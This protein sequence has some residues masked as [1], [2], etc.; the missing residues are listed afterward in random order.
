MPVR[1]I[2]A[3]PRTAMRFTPDLSAESGPDNGN[4]VAL[5]AQDLGAEV[6]DEGQTNEA[7]V[8]VYAPA[9]PFPDRARELNIEGV[10][11]AIFVV[12]Y[13]GKVTVVDIVKS[14]DQL[15]SREVKKTLLQWRFKPAKNK[16]VPVNMRFSKEFE[17]KLE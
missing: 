4:G 6:F 9:A 5:G 10:V 16:G 11:K 3:R 2:P 12:N 7:A 8:A 13:L 14:P 17:F 1:E 15:F